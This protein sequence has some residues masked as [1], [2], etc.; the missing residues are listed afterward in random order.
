MFS[1]RRRLAPAAARRPRCWRLLAIGVSA[2]G[3]GNPREVEEG[4][5]VKVGGLKYTVIFSRY[6]NPKTTTRTPPT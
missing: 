3:S 4:E 5:V 1:A 6:L 2:C